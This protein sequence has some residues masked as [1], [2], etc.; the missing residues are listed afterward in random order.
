M[1]QIL[2]AFKI[3]T[4]IRNSIMSRKSK[5]K[6]RKK[7]KKGLQSNWTPKIVRRYL[8]LLTIRQTM[9]KIQI[10]SLWRTKTWIHRII[11]AIIKPSHPEIRIKD[12]MM[13]WPFL[14]VH[15][16]D[17][18]PSPSANVVP[19]EKQLAGMSKRQ[20]KVVMRKIAW[21]KWAISILTTS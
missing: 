8:D 11:M 17:L 18:Y 6:M 1:D 7:E 19:A 15:T 14:E 10:S 13:A 12:I 4:Q 16:Q 3:K 5:K 20:M 2:I 9:I 21:T